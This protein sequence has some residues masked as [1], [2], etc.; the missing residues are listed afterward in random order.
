M[1]Q[2]FLR[3][4]F[5]WWSRFDLCGYWNLIYRD[6]D[7]KS[8]GLLISFGIGFSVYAGWRVKELAEFPLGIKLMFLCREDFAHQYSL[9]S[10]AVKVFGYSYSVQLGNIGARQLR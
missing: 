7:R 1:W 2:R 9:A 5:R 6:K 10:F 3:K 4:F 8:T